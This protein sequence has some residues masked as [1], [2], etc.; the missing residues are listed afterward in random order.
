MPNARENQILARQKMEAGM[1]NRPM[2]NPNQNQGGNAGLLA[3]L[4]GQNKISGG[5]QTDPNT[6]ESVWTPESGSSGLFGGASRSAARMDNNAMAPTILQSQ[7]AVK[8][9][10]MRNDAAMALQKIINDAGLQQII[11]T[12]EGQIA[13]Q[14]LFGDQA[15]SQIKERAQ[16]EKDILGHKQLAQMMQEDR[17][18]YTP[19]NAQKYASS[20]AD[21]ATANAV[22]KVVMQGDFLNTPEGQQAA[23]ESV[24]GPMMAQSAINA[25]QTQMTAP[26]GGATMGSILPGIGPMGSVLGA[27]RSAQN[28]NMVGTGMRD[29]K[30]G[31]PMMT[32]A[33]PSSEGSQPS[34]NMPIDPNILKAAQSMGAQG[35][36]APSPMPNSQQL[37][38]P[39]QPLPNAYPGAQPG[40]LGLPSQP[41]PMPNIAPDQM[42]PLLQLL[43]RGGSQTNSMNLLGQ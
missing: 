35:Q 10:Q 43:L 38:D 7:N 17:V 16:V 8:I 21:K 3:T 6:G 34:V 25:R 5:L 1:K 22:R 13:I 26:E 40:P 37:A 9:Q 19:E 11:K 23:N 4:F 42:G 27:G 12:R 20:L 28:I 30:T 32:Q 36:Q 24:K 18:P 31:Q 29:P 41:N 2:P 14:N 33:M 39:N 15:L